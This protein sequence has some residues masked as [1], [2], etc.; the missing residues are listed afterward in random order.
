MAY[1]W[2]FI[3]A[4]EHSPDAQERVTSTSGETQSNSEL[5]E[6]KPVSHTSAYTPQFLGQE[7][8]S[9][10]S[11]ATMVA[12]LITP[13]TQQHST[14]TDPTADLYT[15]YAQYQGT[16]TTDPNWNRYT[17]K[18]QWTVLNFDSKILFYMDN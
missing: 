17:S 12:P 7:Y 14:Y 13:V 16:Y 9:S 1:D 10:Q 8:T 18:C 3:L 11:M 6:L 4:T 2:L 5:T 15:G